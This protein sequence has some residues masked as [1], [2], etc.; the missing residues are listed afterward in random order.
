M[1]KLAWA[2]V[3]QLSKLKLWVGWVFFS[4]FNFKIKRSVNP[5]SQ[6]KWVWKQLVLSPM[7]R[8]VCLL[9]H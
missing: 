4:H 8:G 2:T 5:V 6:I 1:D 7:K 9:G 3:G